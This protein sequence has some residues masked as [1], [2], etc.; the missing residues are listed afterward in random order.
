[1]LLCK[2]HML[3]PYEV[4]LLTGHNINVNSQLQGQNLLAVTD[5][6]DFVSLGDDPLPECMKATQN[7]G[8][9]LTSPA[10]FFGPGLVAYSE[11]FPIVSLLPVG[12]VTLFSDGQLR[13]CGGVAGSNLCYEYEPVGGTWQE[14]GSTIYAG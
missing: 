8:Q 3:C 7:L 6:S 14:R 10:L 12:S 5:E 13:G 9:N 4:I 1:M 2:L 11:T